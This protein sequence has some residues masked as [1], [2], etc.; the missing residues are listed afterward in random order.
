MKKISIC[1]PCFNEEKNLLLLYKRVISEINKWKQYSFELIIADNASTDN[2]QNILE[3][4]AHDDSRVK[5]IIN[6]KNFGPNRNCSNAL[7]QAKG[8][9]VITFPADFQTPV[10]LISQYIKAWEQGYPVVLG[11]ISQSK[12]NKLMFCVREI[13]YKIADLFSP[14][15]VLSHVSGG[16]LFSHE[17]IDLI[18]SLD[19]PDPDLRFLITELGFSYKLVPYMQE[20]RKAGRSSYNFVRYFDHAISAFAETS[21][22]MLR[23][24]T[25]IG[26]IATIIALISF[27]IIL[28]Y[29]FCHWNAFSAASYFIITGLYFMGS[30]QL[31]F[32]GMIGEYLNVVIKRVKKR[33]LTVERKKINFDS[34]PKVEFENRGQDEDEG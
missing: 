20:K 34:I 24:I 17:T 3:K 15:P 12:E 19:E 9:A 11:V 29:K 18:K 16:G 22:K 2:S 21:N 5:V 14:Y 23:M 32:I 10:F 7:F 28:V 6:T 4:I 8:D 33:P 1:I 26:A 25:V 30:V 13:Y 31:L 27:L